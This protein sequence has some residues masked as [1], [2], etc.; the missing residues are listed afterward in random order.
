MD[1]TKTQLKLFNKITTSLN[2]IK[3]PDGRTIIEIYDMLNEH[4][5]QSGAIGHH[6]GNEFEKQIE[7]NLDLQEKLI[8][9]VDD[10]EPG[11][12]GSYFNF[13]GGQSD[14]DMTIVKN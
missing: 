5:K 1:L 10:L 11:T 6:F 4:K 3:A 7:E 14:V 2:K 8:R 13:T 9:T 12:Y